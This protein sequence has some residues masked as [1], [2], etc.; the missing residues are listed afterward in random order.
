[1]VFVLM[2]CEWTIL[3]ALVVVSCGGAPRPA[4]ATAAAEPKPTA[5]A[6][7]SPETDATES[8]EP[9]PE[10][11]A[12]GPEADNPGWTS[13]RD[14]S[15]DRT[16]QLP[17]G[18]YFVDGTVTRLPCDAC[19]KP[20]C[21]LGARC[22]R[23]KPCSYCNATVLIEHDRNDISIDHRDRDNMPRYR[24]GERV[25]IVLEKQGLLRW[26]VKKSKPCPPSECLETEPA[27]RL[28]RAPKGVEVRRDG[29]RCYAP[30]ACP[31]NAK[32]DPDGEVRVR[33]P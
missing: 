23:T 20:V 32:C 22:E 1:M 2:S 19:S 25:R 27:K 13:I 5:G 24:L 16:Q 29:E 10:P 26:Y 3:L 6:T 30:Q 7:P 21:E 14:I 12:K 9:P 33:C 31:P 28:G 15:P 18:F 8:E 11:A 17:D 4:P